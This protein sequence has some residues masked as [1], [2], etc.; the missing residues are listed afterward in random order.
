MCSK[1]NDKIVDTIACIISSQDDSSVLPIVFLGTAVGTVITNLQD[2]PGSVMM[3]P[4]LPFSLAR[5]SFM[6]IV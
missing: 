2:T 5:F 3:T 6:L 1:W 4:H